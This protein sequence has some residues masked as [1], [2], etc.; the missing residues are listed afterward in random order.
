VLSFKGKSLFA[1]SGD[2]L[3]RISIEDVPVLRFDVELY[4]I[5]YDKSVGHEVTVNFITD[6]NNDG[7]FFTDSSG[8]AMQE[9]RLNY[10]PTWELNLTQN[11]NITANYYPIGSAMAIR[12]DTWQLTVMN[13]RAQG[14]SV[15]K[16]GRIELM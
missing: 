12:D 11:Q 8:L 13:N 4:G 2:S 14:G 7:V 3:V 6:I 16:N 9:R 15:I 10:R 5:P 1:S